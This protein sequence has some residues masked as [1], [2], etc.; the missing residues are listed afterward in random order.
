MK[1]LYLIIPF[2]L[3][4][5]CASSEQ[6]NISLVKLNKHIQKQEKQ[7]DSLYNLNKK[8]YN[9]LKKAAQEQPEKWL[10]LAKSSDEVFKL[11]NTICQYTKQLKDELKG[12]TVNQNDVNAMYSTADYD[13]FISKTKVLI[14]QLDDF[15]TINK[16]KKVNPSYYIEKFNTHE[17][18]KNQQGEIVNYIDYHFKDKTRVGL[19]LALSKIQ[20]ETRFYQHIYMNTIVN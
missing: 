15:Y 12:N 4:I 16:N 9:F 17:V 1:Y 11:G 8:Q 18:Y 5:S 13:T 10:N 14:K 20:F 19:L 7:T 2:F 6:N 3:I